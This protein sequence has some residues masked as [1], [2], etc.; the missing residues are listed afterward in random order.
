MLGATT[1][2]LNDCNIKDLRKIAKELRKRNLLGEDC[3][4][5]GYYKMR[6]TDLFNAIQNYHQILED[7]LDQNS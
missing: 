3:P 1:R 5:I 7:I 4:L 6:K 2:D